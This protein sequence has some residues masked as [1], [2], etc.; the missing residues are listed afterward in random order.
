MKLWNEK[1]NNEFK[2]KHCNIGLYI[3][4]WKND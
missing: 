3:A 2:E 4:V 1:E